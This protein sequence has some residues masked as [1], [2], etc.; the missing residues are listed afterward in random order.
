MKVVLLVV[1]R[2]LHKPWRGSVWQTLLSILLLLILQ[3]SLG[4]QSIWNLVQVNG[5]WGVIPQDRV[6]FLSLPHLLCSDDCIIVAI[7]ASLIRFEISIHDEVKVLLVLL[8]R[9]ISFRENF[10]CVLVL[11]KNNIPLI[12]THKTPCSC[13]HMSQALSLSKLL[14]LVLLQISVWSSLRRWIVFKILV[15][16]RSCLRHEVELLLLLM[17]LVLVVI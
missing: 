17:L 9:I 5:T 16:T 14:Q 7:S 13:L 3:S 11:L 2:S 10:L 4:T 8:N 12:Q 15:L 6:H 1:G